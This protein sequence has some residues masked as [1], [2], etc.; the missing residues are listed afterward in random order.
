MALQ[1]VME[2]GADGF[3]PFVIFINLCVRIA[4]AYKF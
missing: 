3:A 2:K 4:G 1:G